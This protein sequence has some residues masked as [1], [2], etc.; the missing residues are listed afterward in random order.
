MP[1]KVLSQRWR[2]VTLQTR[3]IAANAARTE[4]AKC[5]ARK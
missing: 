2:F 1:F 5:G 3:P 4:L